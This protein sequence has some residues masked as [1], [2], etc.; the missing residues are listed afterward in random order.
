MCGTHRIL[1]I[2]RVRLRQIASQ[3]IRIFSVTFFAAVALDASCH[4]NRGWRGGMRGSKS[5]RKFALS[6]KKY[7]W[8]SVLA[9]H[10]QHFFDC[11]RFMWSINKKK[12][13]YAVAMQLPFYLSLSPSN[14][15]LKRLQWFSICSWNFM[16]RCFPGISCQPDPQ[17]LSGFGA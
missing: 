15:P 4:C 5:R 12:H 16:P 9:A 10:T 1:H 6:H 8:E 11:L 13:K 2:R 3:K 17:A 14:W 7:S